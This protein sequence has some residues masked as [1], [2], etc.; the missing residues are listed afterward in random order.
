MHAMKEVKQSTVNL[1]I[2]MAA[3]VV[4][5]GAWATPVMVAQTGHTLEQE[6]ND[7]ETNIN[8]NVDQETTEI[9]NTT[10]QNNGALMVLLPFRL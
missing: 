8:T 5:A 10:R 7:A 1:I 3:I 9:E 6:I 2:I 4:A